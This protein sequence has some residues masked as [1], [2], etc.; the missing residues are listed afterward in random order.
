MPSNTPFP[1]PWENARTYYAVEIMDNMS[2][3]SPIQY[4]DVMAAAQVLK[5][6]VCENS[7]S[8]Y[9]DARPAPILYVSG[10]DDLLK[11]WSSKRL[12][13]LI[14]SIGMRD[15]IRALSDSKKSRAS[16]DTMTQKLFTGGFLEMASAQSPSSLRA[17]SIMI[18]IL[19]ELDSAP[20]LLTTG[21]GRFDK[22]AEVRTSGFALRKK[23]LAVSTP[24][25]EEMSLIKKRHALGDQRVYMVPCPFCEKFQILE[26]GSEKGSHG[27]RAET[28]AGVLKSVYYI[29]DH[30]HEAFFEYHKKWFIPRGYWEPTANG[31]MGRRSYHIN[32]LYSAL[33]MFSWF[34]YWQ[35]YQEAQDTPDGMRSFTMLRDGLPFKE[36][37]SRPKL[38]K[39]IELRGGYTAGTV[40]DNVL[41]IVAAMDVQQGSEK[42]ERYP[43]RVEMEIL[44][45]GEKYRTWSIDYKVFVGKVDDPF[46]GAWKKLHEWA[47]GNGLIFKKKSGFK[48]SPVLILID[49]GYEQSTVIG[50]CKRWKNTFPSKGFQYLKKNKKENRDEAGPLNIKRYRAVK[51][52][53]ASIVYEISTNY[54][55]NVIYNSLN[56]PRIDEIEQKPG[57]SDFPIDY[58]EEHFKQLTAEE[59][60]A[61][62][63]FYLPKGRKNERLDCR[64]GCLCAADIYL[65]AKVLDFKSAAKASGAS[66]D[67]LQT[68]NHKFVIDAMVEQNKKTL[69]VQS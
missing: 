28:E 45:I 32:S 50:F 47:E 38:D 69:I 30:C 49:S 39:V 17:D 43:A 42:D 66:P 14:D 67:Q 55:K 26:R 8:Y 3:Y 18:L 16:G 23:I 6:S 1:G 59:K 25:T 48:M 33:G 65:D 27:L 15:K 60:L 68:I 11:K 12:E 53:G 29:C 22:V 21:E 10:T 19:E 63:T 9:M 58:G 51:S 56:I 44:G 31:N 2:P 5:S 62:G 57:F 35:E 64:V 34:N 24:T 52:G 40:P 61:D 4:I 7:V 41:Y 36:S 13:P 20:E 54:Y 37:G 46:E